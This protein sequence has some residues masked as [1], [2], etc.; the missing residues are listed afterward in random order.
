MKPRLLIVF[1]LGMLP[2]IYSCEGP[3]GPAG[4]EGPQGIAGEK[5]DPGDPAGAV[6]FP[7]DTLSTTAQGSRVLGFTLTQQIAASVENG[8]ILVYAKS[9]D[10]WFPLPGLVIFGNEATSFTFAY[11]V[12]NLDF[13]LLL[14]ETSDAPKARKFQKVRVVIV[15]AANGRLNAEL[16]WKNYEEV[17]KALNLPE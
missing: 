5:G 3:E 14:L 8:V 15:P 13:N 6:Q 7:F 4:P 12:D 16:D 17:R 2:F 9:S 10:L 1:L 11:E